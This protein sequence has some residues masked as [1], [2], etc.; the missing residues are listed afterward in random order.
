VKSPQRAAKG[1]E[2]VTVGEGVASNEAL[3]ARVAER[4]SGALGELYTHLAPG[5]LGMA[6]KIL[7]DRASATDIIE[8]TFVRLWHEARRFPHDGS[9]AAA[10]LTL[11][12][13]R[14][15]VEARRA[16]QK[17][18]ALPG[19]HADPVVEFTWLPR[20]E[21]VARIEERRELLKK[22]LNQLPNAQRGVLELVVLEGYTEEEIAAKLGEPLGRVQSGLR[23][24]MRFLR[25]RLRAVL[26]T[27]SANI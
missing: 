9:S 17:L 6:L 3:L 10:W 25:H 7:P 13:R 21:E 14:F 27:W 11:T 8:K 19:T 20:P 2:S 5:L 1:E 22:V 12:A 18:P 16:R 26:G 4:D 23:A 15:A 24:G